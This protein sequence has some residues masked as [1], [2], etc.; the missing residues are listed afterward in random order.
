MSEHSLNDQIQAAFGYEELLVPAI[1]QQWTE[2]VLDAAEIRP[3]HSV[4]D[5]ACGTGVLARAALGR[6]G[7]AGH[8]SGIDPGPGM[9]AAAERLA[10]QVEWRQAT[11]ESLPYPTGSFDAVVSQFGLMFFTERREAVRE[12][13]RVLTPDGRLAVAVWDSLENNS[14]YAAE[15]ALFD[16]L[17]GKPAGDAMRAPFVL[18]SREDLRT[19]FNGAGV[20]SVTIATR[21]G[22]AR[23]A[24]IRSMIEA[25]L[26]GWLPVMGVVLDEERIEHILA[27]AETALAHYVSTDGAMVFDLSAHIVTGSKR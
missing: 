19:L 5:V 25:D 10:P 24:N 22:R 26:R 7:R 27:E 4:L 18:G 16:R 15:V 21:P 12:M 3:G 6:V 2:Q 8:V 17:A 14:A 23:F 20:S 11:A 1:F 9:L 13:L